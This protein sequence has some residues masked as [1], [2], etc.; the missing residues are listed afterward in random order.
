MSEDELEKIRRKKVEELLKFQAMPREIVT[1]N[2]SDDLT[3][4]IKDFNDKIVVIDFWAVWCSPCKTFAPIFQKIHEEFYTN[5]IFAK[6]NVDENPQIAQHLGITSIP[7]TVLL[8]GDTVVRKFVGV[9]NYTTL[10]G[11]LEK[12]KSE[13]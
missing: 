5:F 13:F 11:V 1:I 12:F 3:R 9:L 10:K 6:I 2:N 8:K 4:L 7:T